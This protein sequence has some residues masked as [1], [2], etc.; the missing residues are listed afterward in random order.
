MYCR[1]LL[2]NR[3]ANLF[4]L[5]YLL[6]Y[7]KNLVYLKAGEGTQYH[8]ILSITAFCYF[9]YSVGLAEMGH[10]YDNPDNQLYNIISARSGT[11]SKR[12]AHGLPCHVD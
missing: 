5:F 6:F 8:S 4:C 11:L 2:E 1:V 12:A 7:F 10:P 3:V 9:K